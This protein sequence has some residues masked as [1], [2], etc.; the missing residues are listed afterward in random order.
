MYSTYILKYTVDVILG[1]T[2]EK[3]K[4]KR[5]ISKIIAK[6]DTKIKAKVTPEEKYWCTV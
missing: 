5:R 6:C 3:G 1:A 4:I 2:G